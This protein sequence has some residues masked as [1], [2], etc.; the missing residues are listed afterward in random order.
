[1]TDSLN[2]RLIQSY[3][4]QPSTLPKTLRE[5]LPT[6][7]GKQDVVLY[8][9]ADLDAAH[10]LQEQ[11]V[12]LGSDDLCLLQISGDSEAEAI[13]KIP[14]SS[15]DKVR[16]TA[17]LSGYRWEILSKDP[18]AAPLAKLHFSRRQQ[19]CMENIR[20]LLQAE[21]TPEVDPELAD[22]SYAD[23]LSEPIRNAQAAI[24]G[25]QLTVI[26]RLLS[27]LKPYKKDLWLGG[28][29]AVLLTALSLV[30]P[31]VS[32]LLIDGIGKGTSSTSLQM[33]IAVLGASY[34]LHTFFV[35]LRLS[36]MAYMG[37]R[38]AHDIRTQVYAH[39]QT[40]SLRFFTRKQTGSI[41]S[42]CSS[43]TDRLWDFIAFG[44]IEV[45]LSTLMLF[46]L[47]TVL[48]LLDWRLGLLL[49][50]P[51]P[52]ILFSF[53]MHGRKMQHIFLK[54]FR[55]WSDLTSVLSGT[56]PGIRVVKAFHQEDRETKRFLN[57]ND[58]CL[59]T[60]TLV[61]KVWTRFWPAL[62]FSFHAITLAVYIFALPR[63][64][65]QSEPA[66]STGTFVTFLLY[67]GMFMQ[68][69][70]TI[71]QMT[72]MMNR[73]VS[74]AH[75][76]F[77]ILDTEPHIPE[78]VD[79]I[80]IPRLDGKIQ[81]ENVR[82]SYDG[83]RQV[84]QD[85]SLELQPGEMVGLVGPS[86]A[87]KSTLIQLMVRF[88]DPTAGRILIDG[89]DLRELDIGSYR[90]QV[91]MV[92]QDPYLFHGSIREN[93]AYGLEDADPAAI[94]EAARAAH[95]HE[96]ICKM[97]Q[98]Y[99]TIIGE[100]GQTL[101]GG[102]RQRISIARAILHNPRILILD[103]ATSNVDTETERNIQEALDQLVKGRTVIAIAHRLSTLRRANRLL[104]L[105]DGKLV[106]SGTHEE[107]LQKEGGVFRGLYEMQQELH[108][109]FV[110]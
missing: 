108:Q 18:N 46:G 58:D 77:E 84:L 110:V 17:D 100:R 59:H 76:I 25:D 47:G 16:E 80:T 102:E 40:L 41:I 27:Y 43:D 37:E 28:I 69:L 9:M 92:L 10:N 44:V 98:A 51:V 63:L 21:N 15:I 78:T 13:Q 3:T 86:G 30:P 106:E 61:H 20:L 66:I 49:T 39:L 70:Q 56:I 89:H 60:F 55:K 6:I 82:F 12:L 94:I 26:W 48:L 109:N 38:V 4:S 50:I 93:I 64:T 8:A 11:W 75:R 99:E 35:W 103:E 95:A 14:R 42:R 104:V 83:V 68:P 29:A 62:T 34:L 71:G 7:W 87:G 85:I 33:Y 81:L 23:A 105:K 88:Y 54:A 73:A 67:A 57:C 32:G 22:R 96:F 74:S 24:R 52:F 45:A 107:L 90:T 19:A 1:M 101:S 2:Q 53:V 79:Q 97:P 5:R 91:G 31:R 36:R 72:R 65:G